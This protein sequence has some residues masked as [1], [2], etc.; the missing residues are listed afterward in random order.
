MPKPFRKRLLAEYLTIKEN[1]NIWVSHKYVDVKNM[2]IFI[3]LQLEFKK[4]KA[5][6]RG[7]S[8]NIKVRNIIGTAKG[9]VVKQLLDCKAP[10][11][12]RA[13]VNVLAR[14]RLKLL[15]GGHR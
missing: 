7:Y 12:G 10:R 9:A 1:Y 14:C 5:D 11:I 2:G 4:E 6:P 13:K 3:L 8:H 15:T